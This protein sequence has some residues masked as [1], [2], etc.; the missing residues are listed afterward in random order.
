MQFLQ[1]WLALYFEDDDCLE[2]T[3]QILINAVAHDVGGSDKQL[4]E[5][6]AIESHKLM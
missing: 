1:K 6:M 2:P 4:A 3:F 5:T